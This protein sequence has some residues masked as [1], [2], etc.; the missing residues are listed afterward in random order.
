MAKP[1]KE[2]WKKLDA[3]LDIMV[4][5]AEGK[6]GKL[7]AEQLRD[8]RVYLAGI[9]EKWGEDVTGWISP[10]RQEQLSR[11]LQ[12]K[13]GILYDGVKDIIEPSLSGIYTASFASTLPLVEAALGTTIRG[14][15]STVAVDTAIKT[16]MGGLTIDIRLDKWKI[17]TATR[18]QS[19]VVT[20]LQRGDDYRKISAG[21]KDVF[22]SSATNMAT[23]INTEGHRAE[24]QAGKEVAERAV[25]KGVKVLKTWISMRDNKVRDAHSELDGTTIPYEEK[26]RSSNGGEGDPG[27][28]GT[29]E[30]DINCRCLLEYSVDDD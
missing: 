26:F 15:L 27:E 16:P 10:K 4:K 14:T 2:D 3:D 28:M 18:I 29:A 13:M 21:L 24:I 20:G 23:I 30:D 12:D 5:A 11:M 17:D 9:F 25:Q 19:H 8:F 1:T 22:G 7:Y 6:I